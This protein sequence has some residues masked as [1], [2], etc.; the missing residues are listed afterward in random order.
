LL[1]SLAEQQITRP[2]DIQQEAMPSLLAGKSLVG[3]AE[4]GSGKT[5]AFVLPM[6][7]QLKT[8]EIE[9]HPTGNRS[10]PR[11]LVLVPGRELGEQVAKVFKGLTHLTRLRVRS[12]L[13]G[14]KK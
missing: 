1:T 7:H 13:G 6:L 8:L 2:T 12:C 11:G 3:V 14:T 9:G 10:R 5:L 4:T